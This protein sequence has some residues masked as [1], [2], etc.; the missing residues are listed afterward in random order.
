[1]LLASLISAPARAQAPSPQAHGLV[2]IGQR[3]IP[4][5][6]SDDLAN[7]YREAV[8]EAEKNPDDFGYPA[9]DRAAG[10]VVHRPVTAAGGVLAQAKAADPLRR[11]A[12]AGR[13]W[14]ELEDIKHSLI[15]L[16]DEQIPDAD[17][18]FLAERDEENNRIIVTV[19]RASD[20]LFGYLAK[21]Y[22]TQAV[23]V[24]IDPAGPID[25]PATGG[26]DGDRSPF[27]GGASM[28]ACSSG[29]PW[30]YNGTYAMLTAGHC[31]P[32]GGELETPLRQI[33]Y[34]AERTR[35]N[36]DD[37]RG[38]QL[39]PGESV[40][41]GDVALIANTANGSVDP[42]IYRGPAG[43]STSAA[44]NDMW[45]GRATPGDQ[46]CTGGRMAGESCGWT[47]VEPGVEGTYKNGEKFY[48]LVFGWRQGPNCVIKGDSGGPVYTVRSDGKVA[49]KGITSGGTTE[50]AAE[51][52]HYFT[53]IWDAYYALPGFLLTD[54]T[55]VT[56]AAPAM[57]YG[58]GTS[59]ILFRWY[60]SNT[61]FPRAN[62][63]T[64]SGSYS[65]SQIGDRMAS[66]DFNGDGTDD[67]VV[68]YDYGSTFR[69]HVFEDGYYYQ[70]DAGWYTSGSFAVENVAGRMVVGNW[71]G[72]LYDD[73][74]MLYDAGGGNSRIYTWRSTGS[75]FELLSQQDIA[76]YS[77]ANIG[78]R[79]AAG[80]VDGDGH[81]DIVVAYSLGSTFRFDVFPF[82]IYSRSTWYTSGSF[83]L[84]NV[85]NRFVVGD[86]DEDGD[87]EPALLYDY[88][89]GHVRL[90]RWIS[91]SAVF[92]LTNDWSVA[93]GYSGAL[94]GDRI[95]A[96]DV[97]GDGR[98]DIVT[99]YDYGPNFRYH[100]F[101][102]GYLYQG[103]GGWYTSG[104]FELNNV[105]DRLVLGR[106]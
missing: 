86:W 7:S 10:K 93:S 55:T 56:G 65:V 71:D 58:T 82:G 102:D 1:M 87:A 19:S 100:V 31:A 75:G 27:F 95:A 57:F 97:N 84:S 40:Y 103:A 69:F 13:S 17:A 37:L 49:A 2:E 23:A 43:S 33:G 80:D 105:S 81:D 101:L 54:T 68:A 85:G 104:T 63:W 48:N 50:S 67:I 59:P 22:G 106:W 91:N 35:E 89:G 9:L 66:G 73:V 61:A 88:G 45:S 53:D 24:R 34:V 16:R 98:D 92:Q 79:V 25:N 41:R 38:T 46:Y 8:H 47:V 18:I 62:D 3:E 21:R 78:D 36:W 51:C 6:V 14:R 29:F 11:T 70:G 94:V 72:D 44:I 76:G 26:R 28:V 5:P 60:S 15:L 20:A 32:T 52:H 74:A 4:T 64:T 77:V 96:D 42:R 83:S 99:A 39:F 30:V 12:P 90:W